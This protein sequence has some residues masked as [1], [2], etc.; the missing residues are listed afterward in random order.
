MVLENV[1]CHECKS[2]NIEIKNSPSPLNFP[3]G[4]GVGFMVGLA[5]G[6]IPQALTEDNNFAGVGPALGLVTGTLFGILA[7]LFDF[8]YGPSKEYY[9]NSC[10]Y[11]WQ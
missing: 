6:Q 11:H 1:I 7:F 5:I 2:E 8:P 4:M 3:T 9:C 10:E